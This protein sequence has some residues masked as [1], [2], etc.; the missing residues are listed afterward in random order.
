MRTLSRGFAIESA[1]QAVYCYNIQGGGSMDLRGVTG[2]DWDEANIDKNEEHGVSSGEIEQVFV[3]RPV[4]IVPDVL[5]SQS[6][7]RFL[8]LGT[9]DDGDLLAVAFT[10]REAKCKIRPISAR[11]M[12]RKE[13]IAYE[14]RI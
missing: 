8:A 4:L 6:E 1:A 10:L 11:P 7:D 3:N 12:E 9:T 2:F 13:R 14:K 5:H